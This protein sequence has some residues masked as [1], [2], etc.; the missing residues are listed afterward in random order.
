MILDIGCGW[1]P[2]G[3]VN[4]DLFL[5]KSIPNRE[6]EQQIYLGYKRTIFYKVQQIPNFICCDV[7]HLPFLNDTFSLVIASHILEHLDNPLK[8]IK[9][10][11][12]ICCGVCVIRVP[13]AKMLKVQEENLHIYSWNSSTLQALL[14]RVFTYVH[15]HKWYSKHHHKLETIKLLALQILSEPFELVAFCSNTRSI[16]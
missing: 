2:K 3:D 1:N 12:R 16:S 7:Y 8:A 4:T 14:H 9:E 5:H 6:Y 13:N 10:F 15:I 11:N